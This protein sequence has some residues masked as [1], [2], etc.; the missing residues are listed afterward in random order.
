MVVHCNSSGV[1]SEYPYLGKVILEKEKKHFVCVGSVGQPRDKT[2][3]AKYVIFDT[4][5]LELEPRFVEYDVEAAIKRFKEKGF[6]GYNSER[7]R[8]GR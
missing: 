3:S 5:K 4:K 8:T 1:D 7:L 2:S 6:E